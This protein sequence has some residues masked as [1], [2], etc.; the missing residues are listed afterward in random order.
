[1]KKS[2]CFWQFSGFV[3]T[4]VL[5]TLLHFLFNWT[6]ESI[7]ISLFSAVN[8]SIWEHMKLLYFP[9]LIFTLFESRY[10]AREHKNF[11]CV[12]A[13][14]FFAGLVTIPTLYYTY[15]GALGIKADWFNILIFFIAAAVSYIIE[16][17]II[18]NSRGCFFTPTVS[19]IFIL[20]LGVLFIIF[21]FRTPKI[22]LFEDP[23][24]ST[25]GFFKSI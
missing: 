23:L 20:T 18:K 10:F 17:K 1:M 4:G 25:Y 3:F 6:N 9:M 11:W 19:K 13:V 24:D 8:E 15:T 22:P 7:I 14:G 12:K 2:I 16:T 5:G 21:T